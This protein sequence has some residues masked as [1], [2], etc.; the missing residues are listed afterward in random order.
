[1]KKSD[2]VYILS[3]VFMASTSLFYCCTMWF[4][5]KLPR[6]YPLE[7]AWKWVNEKGVPSQGWYGMQAFAFLA[8]GIV[9]LMVWF[10]L[11]KRLASEQANLKP[12]QIKICGA[13]ATLVVVVC[14]GYMLYHEFGRWGVFASMG[15]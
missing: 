6:Y 11:G 1:M 5:I 4:H 15:L 8:A 3:A 10:G 12:A 13:V 2:V 9:T 14:M 7:H